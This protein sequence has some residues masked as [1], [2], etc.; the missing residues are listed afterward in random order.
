MSVELLCPGQLLRCFFLTSQKLLLVFSEKLSVLEIGG[1][2]SASLEYS[3]TDQIVY[4]QSGFPNDDN[5]I[6]C[7]KTGVISLFSM[8]DLTKIAEWR[9]DHSVEKVTKTGNSSALFVFCKDE[10]IFEIE[11]ELHGSK[12]SKIGQKN[13]SLTDIKKNEKIKNEICSIKKAILSYIDSMSYIF[14]KVFK[15]PIKMGKCIAYSKE[16]KLIALATL[17]GDIYL[18]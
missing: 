18:L 3:P 12:P 9:L 7:S 6:L 17:S 10:K 13:H 8:D 4:A 2:I 11:Y 14:A 5:F 16:K 1:G 15:P